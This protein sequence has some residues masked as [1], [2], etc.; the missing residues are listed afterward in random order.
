MKPYFYGGLALLLVGLFTSSTLLLQTLRLE[1]EKLVASQLLVERLQN[2]KEELLE[3]VSRRDGAAEAYL[4]VTERINSISR[5]A[6]DIFAS[7]EERLSYEAKC[8]DLTPPPD[9]VDRLREDSLQ[10]Q[11]SPG[12]SFW[13]PAIAF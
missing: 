4:A 5:G 1:R 9:L 8:L 2:D 13:L 6:L 12:S 10:R 3:R 11:S 7:Y